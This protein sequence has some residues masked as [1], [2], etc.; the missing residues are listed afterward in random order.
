MQP[1]PAPLTI[2]KL[3]GSVLTRKREEGKLR[4]KLVVRLSEEVAAS[5]GPL[6]LLHGAG[7]FGHPGAL[8]SGLAEPPTVDRTDARRRRAA[9]VVSSSVR[10]L[11]VAVLSALTA[12]GVPAF[13]V[14][15]GATAVNEGGRLSGFDPK[16]FAAAL[17]RGLV[18]VSFGDVVL[19]ERWG[20]SILSA[21]TIVARLAIELHAARVIFVSD[22]D[23][24][25]DSTHGSR[26]RS[27][28]RVDERTLTDLLPRPG[29]PDVTGGIRG[30]L[31]VVL[32]LAEAGVDA[33]IISGLRHGALSQALAGG[34]VHG[35][36]AGPSFR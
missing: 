8:R 29:A 34:V 2:V 24:V 19:D 31:E 1:N 23:G 32:R 18:P 4:P 14:P 28:P 10:R 5:P 3:G 33:G 15:V 26:P 12:A 27:I 6:V 11:H 21:D 9:V 20:Y 17:G 22:V 13:S 7:S 35:S 25:L 30:K 16:P 36:W